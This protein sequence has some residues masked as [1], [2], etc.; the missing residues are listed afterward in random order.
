MRN[1]QNSKGRFLC[2]PKRITEAIGKIFDYPLIVV[3]APMGYGKT[4]AV[5]EHVILTSANLLW[6]NIYDESKAA[7]WSGF[8]LLFKELDSGRAYSLALLGFPDDSVSMHAALTL[9]KNITLPKETVL[10]IDDFHLVDTPEM[11][12]FITLLAANEIKDLHIVLISRFF[13]FF[14]TEE[15]ALKGYLYHIKKESFEF[16]PKEIIDY[17]QYCG[18]SLTEREADELYGLTEGWISALYLLML[19][20]KEGGSLLTS[21]NIYKLIEQAVYNPFPDQIKEFLLSM[22][23]YNSF[24]PEQAA[25]MAP[26]AYIENILNEVTGRNAFVMYHPIEKTYY[27][28]SIFKNFLTNNLKSMG[29]PFQAE[30][31]KKAAGWYLQTGNYLLSMRYSYLGGDFDTLLHALELDK[32]QSINGERKKLLIQYFDGCSLAD[33]IKHPYAVLIYAHRMFLFNE[34]SLFKKSCETFMTIYQN[35]DSK[36]AAYKERL[37]GEYKLLMSFTE[38]NDIEKMAEYHKEAHKLLKEPSLILDN[39]SSWTYGSPSLL[40]LFYRKSGEL[41]KEVQ[42]MRE[43]MPYYCQMTGNHGKGAGEIM[44]AEQFYYRGDF[45]NAEIAMHSAYQV[46]EETS[47]IMLCT[48]FLDIKLRFMQRDFAGIISLFQKLRDNI[49]E[50]KWHTLLHTIDICEADIYCGL[51]MNEKVEAWIKSGEFQSTRLLFPSLAYLNIVYGKVLLADQEYLKLLGCAEEFLNMARIYPNLLAQIYTHIYI[52]A[53]SFQLSRA[54]EAAAALDQALCMAMPDQVYMPFV[55][56]G[57]T[58][59]PLLEK[60]PTQNTYAD[61]IAAILALYRQYHEAVEHMGK[62]DYL[63]DGAGLTKRESEI[64]HL[65]AQGLSNQEIGKRLYISEN[66]VKTHLKSVYAKLGIHSRLS[67]KTHP[68]ISPG[69]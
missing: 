1:I 32:G 38:Y 13:E 11:A 60:L 63:T 69:G 5:R 53:A 25:Y 24:T 2:F 17:Y 15:L 31:Y 68:D 52:A 22:S 42:I 10:V 40:F 33:K 30:L 49:F 41:S 7:F 48:I 4:T 55:E 27:I 45:Q 64:A 46:A 67:I 20:Y 26:D 18:I 29:E 37:L 66:T 23:I 56:N 65:A 51:H 14:N 57:D 47:D 6:Q 16:N 50:K 3:E 12:N 34:M 19:N 35:I 44:S 21:V 61:D 36:D 54:D 62:G 9:I 28:H 58:I 8:C 43:V 39:R 59:M